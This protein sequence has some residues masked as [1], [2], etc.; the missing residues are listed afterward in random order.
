[1]NNNFDEQKTN[2]L[3]KEKSPYLLQHAKNPVD[4]YAWGEEAF[5][6]AKKED[7][8]VFL[9]IGYS[10]CHWCHVME[11]ESFEDEETAAMMNDV[12]IN[13]KVDR[14]ER[15]D[16]DDIYMTVC[17]MLTGSGGWPLTIVM[18]PDKKPFFAATYLPKESVYG[19]IG[20]KELTENVRSLWLSRRGDILASAEEITERLNGITTSSEGELGEGVFSLAFDE[21]DARYDSINGG[22][23]DSPKFPMPHNLSFLLRY[24][25]RE[26]NDKALRIVEKTLIKMRL[27]GI[28]DQLGNGFH[29]YSTDSRWLVPHFEK[30]LYDQALLTIAYTEAYQ[31]GGNEFFASTA[32]EII[33]YV[34]RDMTSPEGAFYSAED[35]DSEG[36]EGKFYLWKKEEIDKILGDDAALFSKA[37]DISEK[38]NFSEN[39]SLPPDGE[40]IPNL[41]IP[42]D[43]LAKQLDIEENKLTSKLGNMRE[44]LF[45]HRENRV[46]P[47]LDDK[48][49]T[50]WNG[51]MI[52]ALAIASKVFN[53]KRYSQAAAKAADF[54]LEKMADNSGN[55][56][57]RYRD[58][59]AAID[60]ML[61][62]YAFFTWGL[63]EL[64]EATFEIK[65]LKE[66][67]RLMESVQ[68]KFENPGGGYFIAPEGSDDLIT[69][70]AELYDGAVPS[71]NSIALLNLA[72][73]W[74]I[75]ADE[76][77]RQ[78]AEKLMNGFAKMVNR[79]PSAFTQFLI[80]A[81]FLLGESFEIV[82]AGEKEAG[83][84]DKMSSVI[85]SDFIPNKV[86]IH[87]PA[88]DNP[89]IAG[90]AAYTKDQKAPAGQVYA[91]ICRNFTCNRP[92]ADLSELKEML[93]MK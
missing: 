67:I 90:I 79:S 78:R 48:T 81:E 61:D 1:M 43:E 77:Y 3:I 19:R 46:R 45:T 9:S 12:F 6:R 49:L 87:R 73:L 59:D 8:P 88:G 92:T 84:L 2:R 16:V 57:H 62:D 13:I 47:H 66:A 29:R 38:G 34:L 70:K 40:N 41:A 26:G 24:W 63:L 54:I 53:E 36:I 23:G 76:K 71:G 14:E 18:T 55:L 28:Y 74:K 86:I 56:L 58:G 15:P 85:F 25:K 89:E 32:R 50:D 39:P 42:L 5:D 82:L 52:A 10:T 30:M 75:T 91:Y 11:K 93:G 21:L 65:Y 83:H 80:G 60:G 72:R 22:F 27:G 44:K 20:M 68:E 37:Y 69:R 17:Q 64:Y 4:W 31:A 7:K 33:E 35:A 51:L